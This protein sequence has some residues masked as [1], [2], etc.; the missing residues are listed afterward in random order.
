MF[1]LLVSFKGWPDGTGSIPTGRIYLKP[2][3]DPDAAFFTDGKLDAGKV[4]RIPAL[5][6]SETGGSGIQLARV[7]Y[8]NRLVSGQRDTSIQYVVDGS[9]RPISNKDLEL[10]ADQLGVTKNTLTHTHWRVCDA[11]LFRVM[12]LNQ[13]KVATEPKVFSSDSIHRQEDDLVS[14]MMPFGA[15]FTPVYAALQAAAGALGLRCARADDI[16]EHPAVIQDIVNLIARARV[17][18]CDCSGKN[19]NVF[20]EIGI[21]HSLGKEV[22]LIA[23]SNDDVPFD[24]R[25][26]RYV[27]Y[28]A[29]KEGLKKLSKAVQSRLQTVVGTAVK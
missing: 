6:V 1:H 3:E 2:D 5:L 19:P 11:D 20:Y 22:V 27:H 29:N 15:A 24:V 14:V 21:A 10:F 13:Q 18:I 25:H 26:L 9:I 12:L 23:Q 28:L 8:I 7:A 16:W 4:G 17:V